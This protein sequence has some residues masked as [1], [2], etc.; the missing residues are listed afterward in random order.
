MAVLTTEDL[1][2]QARL[3]VRDHLG[4]GP[5]VAAPLNAVISSELYEAVALLAQEEQPEPIVPAGPYLTVLLDLAKAGATQFD[6]VW[7]IED[8]IDGDNEGIL[9]LRP[10]PGQEI[11]RTLLF[12]DEGE[13]AV[14]AAGPDGAYAVGKQGIRDF[15]VRQ[16]KL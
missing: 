12:P 8:E 11:T 15:R 9:I 13:E 7:Q 1:K 10:A 14:E 2:A 3:L 5:E 16:G 6:G 4:D